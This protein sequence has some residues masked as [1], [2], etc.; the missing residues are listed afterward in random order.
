MIRVLTLAVFSA[1]VLIGLY[2]AL[3]PEPAP[4]AGVANAT[5]RQAFE[6]A[7]AGGELVAG[8]TVLQVVQGTEV[9]IRI[10]ADRTDELHL[11]GYDL[12]AR[13]DAGTPAE[14]TF[15]AT[16]SGRFDLELHGAHREIA[17][18]EVVPE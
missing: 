6:L 12:S 14:L 18:L 3:R 8:P 9:T 17:A 16:R 1:A 2:I 4:P 11:H 5:P 10:R 13:I 15:T 7:V